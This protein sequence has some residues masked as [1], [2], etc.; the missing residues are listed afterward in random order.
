MCEL[1]T[2]AALADWLAMYTARALIG[3]LLAGSAGVQ[4][5]AARAARQDDGRQRQDDVRRRLDAR[6]PAHGHHL[7]QNGYV[8][9]YAST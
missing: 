3:W 6:R 2:H 4:E 7:Q 1:T 9:M 8:L 5:E